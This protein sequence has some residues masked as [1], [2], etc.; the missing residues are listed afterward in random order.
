LT[1]AAKAVVEISGMINELNVN[2]QKQIEGGQT[3]TLNSRDRREAI[4]GL[5]QIKAMEQRN[6]LVIL[7]ERGYEG[8]KLLSVEDEFGVLH[9]K[10]PAIAE[11]LAAR[12]AT[13]RIYKTE[14]EAKAWPQAQRRLLREGSAAELRDLALDV[15]AEGPAFEGARVSRPQ[16]RRVV[17]IPALPA[18]IAATIDR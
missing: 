10:L 3:L 2:A 9:A 1:R 12:Y 4:D 11:E 6:A 18:E 5:E 15:R 7:G 8:R 14:E 16:R 17:E 13:A